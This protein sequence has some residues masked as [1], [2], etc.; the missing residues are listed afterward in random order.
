MRGTCQWMLED[1]RF[2]L[3]KTASNPESALLWIHAR[4]GRGKSVLAATIIHHLQALTK[5]NGDVCVY[6]FCRSDDESKKTPHAILRSTAFWL[7]QRN[8]VI[9]RRLLEFAEHCSDLRIDE[10]PLPSSG[11][12]YLC[13]AYANG[14]LML[15]S[16]ST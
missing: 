9:R 5:T 11:I 3:W 13:S 16:V 6:F 12:G 14:G 2:Q 4:A 15:N 7:A 10:L 1:P 8:E